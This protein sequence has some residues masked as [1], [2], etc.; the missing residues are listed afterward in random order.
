MVDPIR[1]TDVLIIGGGPAGAAAALSLVNYSNNSVALVEKSDFNTTRVGEQVS[2]SI[3]DLLNYLKLNKEDFEAS[4]FMPAYANKAYWG[5]N[6][7]STTQSIFTMEEATYQIDR[8]KFDLKL[9]EV[10]AERGVTVFPRTKCLQYQQLEDKSW[11][12]SVMHATEGKFTIHANYLLDASGRSGNVGRQVGVLSKKHDNL[13][14]V[15]VFLELRNNN[16]RFEQTI[17]STELGWWYTACLP[18]NRMVATFFSDA[19][20]ISSHGL[21]KMNIWKETLQTTQHVKQLLRETSLLSEKLWVRNAQTQITDTTHV[22]RFLAIGDA[23]ASF[24]PI[25]SMGIGFSISSACHAA[26]HITNELAGDSSKTEIF[27]Q[28]IKGN[29]NRYLQLRMRFYQEERRWANAM[30]WQRRS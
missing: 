24:D 2:A 26:K 25:S 13:M 10:A 1:N 3:F 11:R 30:F 15:G 16:L 29:F 23:A 12:V 6:Q 18:G 21:H 4:S 22:S 28:D 19:D 14:G 17:E 27:Q 7:V 20:I 9:I 5:S 8:E